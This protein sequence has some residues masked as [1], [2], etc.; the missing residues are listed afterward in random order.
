MIERTVSSPN[1]SVRPFGLEDVWGAILHHTATAGDSGAAVARMFAQASF[2]VAAHDVIDEHGNVWHCVPLIRAAWQAGMC[3][4]YDWNR[5]GKLQDWE[6]YVNTHTGGIELCNRGDGR[7]DF[8][9]AQIRSTAVILRRWDA[10]C[11]NF[12]LRN[13]TDHQTVNLNG[14]IDMRPNFPAAKLFW[15]IL[16]PRSPVPSGGAYAQLPDW[17]KKQVDEIK[18]D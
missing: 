18:R 5:D 14:K 8:P 9:D 11:P 13:I 17:A 16:H 2:K 7:D 4:A 6:R 15:W 1:H 10:K 12:K 3:R